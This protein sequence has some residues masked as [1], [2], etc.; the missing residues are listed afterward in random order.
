MAY[1]HNSGSKTFSVDFP[2]FR[3]MACPLMLDWGHIWRVRGKVCLCP[4]F[5]MAA[6]VSALLWQAAV[7]MTMTAP[8]GSEIVHGPCMEHIAVYVA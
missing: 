3:L 7:S 8:S 4:A 2:V 5:S 6:F 1:S